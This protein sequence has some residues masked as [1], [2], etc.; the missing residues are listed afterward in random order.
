MNEAWLAVFVGVIGIAFGIFTA[1]MM[2]RLVAKPIDQLRIAADAV[3]RGNLTV[4]LGPAGA[5]RADEFGR[6]LCEF[7][8]MVRELRDKEKL[9]QTFGLHV[10]R[11]AAERILARDPGL[12]GVEEEI[13]VMFVD[14]RSWTARASASPPAEIVEVM[15]DFFRVSVRAVEEE[16]RGMVNKYLGDGFMAIFGAGDTSSNHV[17]DAVSA[18]REILA[19]G[20][21]VER[22]TGSERPR[23]NPNWNW[24]SFRPGDCGQRRFPATAGVHCDRRHGQRSL[25]HTRPDENG[26]QTVARHR[27]SARSLSRLIHLRGTTTA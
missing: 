7:D 18:G 10:G 1:L 26:G 14:M 25:A 21:R 6:L 5:A 8:Q 19:S 16:H 22:R 9:R 4:D 15:N 17:R 3:S 24:N 23:A 27:G 12:S 13:T 20:E 11:R 2:S